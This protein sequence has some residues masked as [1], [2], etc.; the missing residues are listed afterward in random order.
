MVAEMTSGAILD[1][2]LATDRKL[3]VFDDDDGCFLMYYK[4][5]RD[6]WVFKELGTR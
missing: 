3:L 2:K 1:G 6:T 5:I 4:H